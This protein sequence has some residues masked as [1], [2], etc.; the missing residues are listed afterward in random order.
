[1]TEAKPKGK[2]R[3]L[4]WVG[5]VFAYLIICGALPK[6]GLMVNLVLMVLSI[7]FLVHPETR[8]KLG[9][10]LKLQAPDSWKGKGVAAGV[11]AVSFI[12]GLACIGIIVEPME[13]PTSPQ[14]QAGPTPKPTPPP[15]PKPAP[16][17]PP[18]PRPPAPVKKEMGERESV[19][20]AVLAGDTSKLGGWLAPRMEKLNDYQLENF[21]IDGDLP[22]GASLGNAQADAVLAGELRARSL[23]RLREHLVFYKEAHA[24]FQEL[25][26]SFQREYKITK[27]RGYGDGA[28]WAAFIRQYNQRMEPYVQNPAI[29]DAPA[30]TNVPGIDGLCVG[31][32]LR[33]SAS[34]LSML[35]L[36]AMETFKDS[37][38]YRPGSD[39]MALHEGDYKNWMGEASSKMKAYEAWLKKQGG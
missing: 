12:F 35:P 2:V 18:K 7:A 6:I 26:A 9:A 21:I 17:T 32:L 20:A 19:T 23:A 1:M 3:V 31:A 28:L 10:V 22:E 36:D 8:A 16:D 39:L 4:I 15:K 33:G 14:V 38:N 30:M 11:I 25:Y 27:G 5:A 37:P 29:K 13:T 24:K 34:N